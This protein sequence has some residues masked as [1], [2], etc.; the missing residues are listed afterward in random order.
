MSVYYP[1]GWSRSRLVNASSDDIT[2]LPEA[3]KD[4]M[5][6]SLRATLGPDGFKALLAE[7]SQNYKARLAAEQALAPASD[8]RSHASQPARSE[9]AEGEGDTLPPSS[10]SAPFLATLNRL[11]PGPDAVGDWGFVVYRLVYEDDEAWARFRARWNAIA[12]SRLE[13]Y[14]AVPGL[15]RARQ[16]VRF[17]WVE[18]RELEG[19]SLA[20]VAARYRSLRA[21]GKLPVGLAHA[22]CLG[23]TADSMR[24]V[25]EHVI[26]PP[27]PRSERRRIP[28]VV[29]VD[30]AL[31]DEAEG[32]EGHGFEGSF[33]VAVESLLDELFVVMGEDMLSPRELGTRL[34]GRQVWCSTAGRTG[35]F[36]QQE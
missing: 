32:E 35:V 19:A 22:V 15:A 21:E 30:Q 12:A 29:A 3:E 11:Y 1:S 36:T 34:T 6:D 25:L 33:N 20:D 18:E 13:M 23:V 27:V 17:H 8:P 28:F 7:M 4:R 26:S 2:A 10:I 14:A 5:Y 31:G 16:Q 9:E 24:S